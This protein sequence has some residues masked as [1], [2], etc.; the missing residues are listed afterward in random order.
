MAN[1]SYQNKKFPLKI[2]TVIIVVVEIIFIVLI[3]AFFFLKD[4]REFSD[5]ERFNSADIEFEF[6]SIL[7]K[8]LFA[9][10]DESEES[11]LI[12]CEYFVQ[13]GSFKSKKAAESQVKQLEQINYLATVENVESANN[14]NYIVIVGPFKNKSQTNNA[15]EDFRRLNMDSLPPKCREIKNELKSIQ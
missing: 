7:E 3:M 1:I 10:I 2:K 12:N 15:R 5:L 14:F 9:T 6:Q 11:S 13:S 8:D 4:D